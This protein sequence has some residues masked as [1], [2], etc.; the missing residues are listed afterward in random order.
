MHFI[1]KQKNLFKK[2]TCIY[3]NMMHKYDYAQ[4]YPP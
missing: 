3:A 2:Q 1:Y 4:I